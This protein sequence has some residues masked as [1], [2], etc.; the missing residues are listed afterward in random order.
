MEPADPVSWFLIERGWKVADRDGEEVGAVDEIVGDSTDD[1]FNGL[2]ISTTLL[3]KPRYVPAESVGTITE[4]H[5]RLTLTKDEVD[6]LDE[7]E[8]PATSAEISAEGAG[9]LTRAEASVEAPIRSHEEHV[10]VWRRM[11]LA[12]R[13]AFGR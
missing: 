13:R 4:G 8:E 3:G 11:W 7:Y 9:L 5:V 1:I 6:G 12:V 10:N 2:A